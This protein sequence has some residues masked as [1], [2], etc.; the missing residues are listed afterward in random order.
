[1]NITIDLWKKHLREELN[2]KKYT[3]PA[4]RVFTE[5]Q[6]EIALEIFQPFLQ[7]LYD[8]YRS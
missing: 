1:M 8:T 3:F 2:G 7:E 4:E 6:V 5:Q